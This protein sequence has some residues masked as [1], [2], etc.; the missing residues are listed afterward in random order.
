MNVDLISKFKEIVKI[1]RYNALN[2][3]RSSNVSNNMVKVLM[4]SIVYDSKKHAELFK[5]LIEIIHGLS[6]PLSEEEY[7]KLSNVI[8]EHIEIELKMIRELEGLL[9]F[10][11]DERLKYVLRYVLDDEKRHHT[12]LLGLQE[13]INKKEVVTDFDWFNI[14][15]KDVPFFF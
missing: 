8:A 9:K 11:D 10:I 7:V 14:I 5:A 13:V 15:W 12:L 4:G 1:E 6:K 3:K 2:L